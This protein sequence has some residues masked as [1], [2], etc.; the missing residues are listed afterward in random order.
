MLAGLRPHATPLGEW[1]DASWAVLA[2]FLGPGEHIPETWGDL[3]GDEVA[4]ETGGESTAERPVESKTGDQ[5][6]AKTVASL[7]EDDLEKWVPAFTNP[8]ITDAEFA[9]GWRRSSKFAAGQS[10]ALK[11]G[12]NAGGKRSTTQDGG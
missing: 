7:S 4:A 2:E 3:T 6:L 8:D 5:S 9:S 11:L 12:G 1:C 10:G